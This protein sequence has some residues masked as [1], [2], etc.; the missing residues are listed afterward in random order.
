MM[1]GPAQVIGVVVT[2]IIAIAVIISIYMSNR[3]DDEDD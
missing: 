2:L 1:N 3:G